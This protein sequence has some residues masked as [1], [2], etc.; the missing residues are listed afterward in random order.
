M[1]RWWNV[2]T[3]V[4]DTSAERREG[5]TPS[6]STIFRWV[7]RLAYL[8]VLKTVMTERLWGF[9]PLTHRHREYYLLDRTLVA[10]QSSRNGYSSIL[11]LSAILNDRL[12]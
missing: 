4:L 1:L 6:L 9:D 11:L 7:V 3:L 2:D 12:S 5:S 8:S 10:N